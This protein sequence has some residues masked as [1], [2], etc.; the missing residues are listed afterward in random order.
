MNWLKYNLENYIA[1]HK[2]YITFY[3]LIKGYMEN[4]MPKAGPLEVCMYYGKIIPD[5]CYEFFIVGPKYVSV[6][7]CTIQVG[8]IE[9]TI[10]V[11]K[12]KL[13]YRK[14]GRAYINIYTKKHGVIYDS[15]EFPK[16]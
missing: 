13:L 4:V 5:V 8:N 11:N 12:N 10:S 1:E 2:T 16:T 9:H 3:A 6:G 14:K 15:K 7:L